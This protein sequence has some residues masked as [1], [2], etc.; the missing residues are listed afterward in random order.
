MFDIKASSGLTFNI[1]FIASAKKKN[2]RLMVEMSEYCRHKGLCR[3][4]VLRF[5]LLAD[6][7]VDTN[8]LIG[9]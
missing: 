4:T 5:N 3:A 9:N 7:K 6:T 2:H 1:W 8:Q